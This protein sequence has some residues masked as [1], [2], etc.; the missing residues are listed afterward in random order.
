MN[1][2]PYGVFREGSRTRAGVAVG[3]EI[4]DL[5]A[6]GLYIGDSLNGLMAAG[7]EVWSA[8]RAEI[9]AMAR[10]RRFLVPRAEVEMQLPAR[11]G[12]YTDFYASIHHATRVGRLF[13]PSSPLPPNYE[14]VPI[15][16][17]GRASSIV[18]DGSPIRRPRGQIKDDS[19]PAPR[20]GP[21]ERLD[22]EAELGFFTGPGNPLGEPIPIAEAERHIFGFCVVN[23]WSARDIQKWEYQP[24]GPFLAKSFA[25]TISP[26]IVPLDALAPYRV[27]PPERAAPLAYLAGGGPGFD[28]TIEVRLN[29]KR[30]SLCSTRHLYWTPAQM[31]A[32]HT[33]NGC[34]LRPGDLIASGTVS[35][36]GEGESGCLLELGGP[37]LADGDEVAMRAWCEREGL[38]RIDFGECRGRVAGTI[39][40]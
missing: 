23:D 24:L 2:F 3:D 34:N 15:A 5:T 21:S 31:V 33:S 12:D 36:P 16:Y 35:G 38:P 25:T 40:I 19:A 13:R 37:F 1:G 17:H 6:C 32:H 4:L 26:W 29:G 28:I 14:H 10:E 11:I 9:P 20:F 8:L 22:Y 7:P 18:I 30:V 39:P 27:P